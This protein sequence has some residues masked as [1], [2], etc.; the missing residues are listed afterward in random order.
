MLGG[1]GDAAW[2]EIGNRCQITSAMTRAFC[3]GPLKLLTCSTLV[4]P[5]CS[6]LRMTSWRSIESEHQTSS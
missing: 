4:V 6:T 3:R 2:L 5:H 1:L